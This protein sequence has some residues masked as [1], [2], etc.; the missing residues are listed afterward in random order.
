VSAINSPML[1]AAL[2]LAARGYHVLV[3]AE[4][5]KIPPKG[6][7]GLDDTTVDPEK[8]KQFFA[9]NPRGNIGIACAASRVVCLDVDHHKEEADGNATLAALEAELGALPETVETMTGTGGRHLYFAAPAGVEFRGSLGLGLDVRFNAYCVC[10]PSIHPDTDNEYRWIR[11]PLD[12]MPAPLPEAWLARMVKPAAPVA[13]IPAAFKPCTTG[14][15]PYGHKAMDEEL[16]KVRTATECRNNQLNTSALALGS[17]CAGGEVEDCRPDLVAAAIAAGLGETESQKTVES[18][19]RAG[20]AQPRTAPPRENRSTPKQSHPAPVVDIAS[21]ETWPD[22]EPLPEGR[23]PVPSFDDVLIPVA[24]RAW[25]SDIAERLQCAPE[26]GTAAALVALASV[27]GRKCVIRPKRFDDWQCVPNLW[28]AVVAPPSALKSPAIDE[29][30]KPLRRLAANAATEH[31][32]A[33]ERFNDTLAIRTAAK[34][35]KQ[36][37]L[38]K[39]MRAGKD[40]KE[41]LAQYGDTENQEPTERRHLVNDGT[42]E[43]IGDLAVHNPIGFLV[44]R[45]ELTGWFAS[46][47]RDGHENDRAFYLESWAGN[48]PYTYDRIGRGTVHIPALCLS[49]FGGIQPGPLTKY[50]R[51]S[52]AGGKGHDGLVQRFQVLVFPD[53]PRD[54][55]NVDRWPDTSA[56]DRAFG[57]FQRLDQLTAEQIGAEAPKFDGLPFLRFEA[58]AQEFADAWRCDLMARARSGTEHPAIEAHLAKYPSLHPSLALIC[59]LADAESFPCGPV[60]LAAA[61]RAAV[62]CGFLEVHARRVYE[63]VAQAGLVAARALLAKITAGKV[64]AAFSAHDVYEQ[65]WSGLTDKESVDAA[66]GILADHGFLREV[67]EQTSGRPRRRFITHPSLSQASA[68]SPLP[69]VPGVPH[70]TD[71]KSHAGPRGASESL[72]LSVGGTL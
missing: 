69:G 14:G 72:P 57:T 36:E 15:T 21:A 46:L 51:E 16:E 42:T 30:L 19:W 34:A 49:L 17:L 4:R 53:P 10:P 71:L 28:G 11:S 58:E 32:K 54:Y 8:L 68:P 22:P 43:K 9:A 61:K 2:A 48:S 39:A 64:Q 45:D 62:L 12:R 44:H 70:P 55:R 6:S 41:V 23:F 1:A 50:L 65:G 13:T 5:S 40:P 27:I 52:L 31:Q 67:T 7:H 18:G 38:K 63:S 33:T 35:V 59:H 47:D 25:L 3:L 29:A 60:S 24:L 20:L 37:A 26:Y 56:R 66:A